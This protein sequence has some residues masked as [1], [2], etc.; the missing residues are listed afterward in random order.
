M[1]SLNCANAAEM[2]GSLQNTSTLMD[3]VRPGMVLLGLLVAMVILI[4]LIVFEKDV[5]LIFGTSNP[6]V[7]YSVSIS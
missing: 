2:D 1:A 5:S 4:L 7:T 6:N 3:W